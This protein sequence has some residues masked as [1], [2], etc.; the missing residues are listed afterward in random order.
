MRS[1]FWK[2]ILP[3]LLLLP[4]GCLILYFQN[5]GEEK[6]NIWAS[7][8]LCWGET[9]Q[10]FGKGNFSYKEAAT[11]SAR[12][13]NSQ[14]EGKVGVILTIVT[15]K[16]RGDDNDLEDYIRLFE[17]IPG[18]RVILQKNMVGNCVL[19]SQ[20]TRM[21]A[22]QYSFVRPND[23]VVMSDAD[24]WLV[25]KPV[26]EML[27]KPSRVWMG[28]YSHTESSGG[29][30]PMLLATMKA[31]DWKG[32]LDFSTQ[33]GGGPK[34][35]GEV[36]S[37][38]KAANGNEG[39]GEWEVDQIILSNAILRPDRQLCSLPKEN[40]LWTRLKITPR[41]FNDTGVCFHGDLMNC[42]RFDPHRRQPCPW[43]HSIT[44]SSFDNLNFLERV[45]NSI[46][47]WGKVRDC[48]LLNNCV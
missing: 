41:E 18:T 20:V 2:R 9:A 30:F 11:F 12:L 42:N 39:W 24:L 47:R 40:K 27:E 16:Q 45:Y 7:I 3:I 1:V 48:V 22:W 28:E 26:L 14:T 13:W 5:K 21:Y 4:A 15:D 19:Q 46:V 34:E 37:H 44:N 31:S 23:V 25:R 29:T 35:M 32:S 8:A 33:E 36:I 43:W 38:Y 17:E 10:V 6:I